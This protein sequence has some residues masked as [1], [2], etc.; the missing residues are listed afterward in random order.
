MKGALGCPFA[1]SSNR[2]LVAGLEPASPQTNWMGASNTAR[3]LERT[4]FKGS[5]TSGLQHVLCS[6]HD[7]PPFVRA[8]LNLGWLLVT[9]ICNGIPIPSAVASRVQ[10]GSF[11]DCLRRLERADINSEWGDVV[12]IPPGDDMLERLDATA[13]AGNKTVIT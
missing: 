5:R 4:K 3:P 2:W 7:L 11:E 8:P 12:F 9:K 6:F 10:V 13:Q 1:V